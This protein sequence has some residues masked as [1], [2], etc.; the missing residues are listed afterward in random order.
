MDHNFSRDQ[1]NPSSSASVENC[2]WLDDRKENI[3][4]EETLNDPKLQKLLKD[5]DT[6]NKGNKSTNTVSFEGVQ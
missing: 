3:S 4:W 5:R 1:Y 2:R 6:G